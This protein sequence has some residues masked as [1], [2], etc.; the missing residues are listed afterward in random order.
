MVSAAERGSGLIDLSLRAP[1]NK[2]SHKHDI[3]W[4]LPLTTCLCRT[5]TRLSLVILGLAGRLFLHNVL[6]C[7]IPKY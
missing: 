2:T 1:G 4:T 7:R 6:S 3:G 5:E